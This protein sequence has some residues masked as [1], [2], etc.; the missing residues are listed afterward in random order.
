MIHLTTDARLS[1]ILP[2]MNKAL[3]EAIKNATPEQ[4]ETLKEGKDLKSVLTSVFQDK[5]TSSKSDTVLLD[6]LKNASVFKTMDNPTETLKSLVQDLKTYQ[7]SGSK[8]SPEVSAKTAVLESFL[9]NGAT[10]DTTALKTQI[11]NSG[12]FMESK[13][14]SAVQKIPDLTRTL[15]QL[16]TLI[17]NNPL[18]Q[19]KA[20]QEKITT[21]LQSPQ[22]A[23]A[24]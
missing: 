5:I 24:A 13:L 18:P 19:G 16:R 20:L 22:L 4:L 14:A 15:E 12:V 2:N 1:I 11:V 6:I 17:S 10:I 7:E 21:I 8:V 9:K 23:A 3:S